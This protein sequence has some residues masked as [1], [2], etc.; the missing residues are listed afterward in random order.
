MK[1][2]LKN[3]QFEKNTKNDIKIYFLFDIFE[4]FLE[5][6]V[7][8]IQDPSLTKESYETR[9]SCSS[10]DEAFINFPEDFPDLN[11]VQNMD[12]TWKYTTDQ[13]CQYEIIFEEI[14]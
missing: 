7:A 3:Q 4:Q 5:F 9:L 13:N 12:L 8:D 6:P 11:I 1:K 14:R 10:D 2:K